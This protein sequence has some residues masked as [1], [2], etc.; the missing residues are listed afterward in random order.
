M[1]FR[2]AEQINSACS[3][4][5]ELWI[6]IL[7][8]MLLLYHLLQVTTAAIV[9][10]KQQEALPF[11]ATLRLVRSSWQLGIKEA[12]LSFLPILLYGS[13]VYLNTTD[14]C[15]CVVW[16]LL[17]GYVTRQ[18]LGSETKPFVISAYTL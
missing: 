14:N 9:V 13:L 17:P 5:A 10:L 6:F 7:I 11:Q 4:S 18:E 12:F 16:L 8:W 15:S 3:L 2:S 1:C